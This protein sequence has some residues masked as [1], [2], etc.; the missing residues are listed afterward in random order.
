MN[1]DCTRRFKKIDFWMKIT[2]FFQQQ[3]KIR[4]GEN[5]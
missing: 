1:I 2:Q 5:M 3:I 4:N